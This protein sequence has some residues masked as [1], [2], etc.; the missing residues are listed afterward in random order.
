[1][2][3]KTEGDSHKRIHPASVVLKVLAIFAVVPCLI[4][5]LTFSVPAQKT[6]GQISGSVLDPNGAVV[7]DATVKATQVGTGLERTA[8]TSSEGNYSIP[9]LPI[10]VYRLSV[11][12]SGFKETIAEN[13]TVNVASVTRQDF[14]MAI[15]AVGEVVTIQ[16]SDIQVETETGAVG[17]VINGQQVRELPLNGRSFVQLTQL[18]PGV[19]PQN[20]FDSK[21]KGLFAGVDFSVNG[22]S[23]Q[24]N[25]FLTDGANNNDTGSNRTILL[26]PS[27][28]AIAEF[29][30]LRNS[31]GPEYGQA[32]GAVISIATR[33]GE[34]KFHGSLFYFGRNDALNSTEFF[35]NR[36]GLG[37]DKLRRNDYGFSIGGPIIKDRLFFFGSAEWNK[38]IRGKARRGSVPTLAERSGNFTNRRVLANG[39][40]CDGGSLTSGPGAA[41]QIIPAANLSPAGQTLVKIYPEPNIAWSPASGNCDNWALSAN[42]PINFR[43]YNI[44]IDYN[45]TSKHKIFGRFTDDTWG[46]AFP[47]IAGGLWGDDAFP[48]IETAWT[49]PARQAAVK[50]TSTLSNTAINEVQFSYSANRINVD[51]GNGADLNKAINTAI[52]GFFPDSVKVNGLNRP[53]PVFWG[54]ITPFYS[55]TGSDL[56]TQSPFRNALDIYSLR[57]D[58][59]KVKGNHTLKAGF[60]Y[61]RAS[62]NEDSGPNNEAVQF[63]GGGASSGGSGNGLADFLTQGSFFGFNESDKQAVGH[64]R[65]SNLEF[66]LGDT[67]KVRPNITLELGA[68]YSI[69]FETYD[70]KNAITSFDPSSYDAS[71]PATDPCNGLVVPKGAGNICQGVSSTVPKEF[72]NRALRNNNFKNIAP[73]LGV[74]WDVF[75]NGKTAI[76]GG[77]GQFFLR[78]RTSPVFAALTQ[79]PP[80]VKSIG[81]QRT[82]DGTAF[83]DLP[84]SAGAGSPKFSFD[85][86]AATPYSWQFNVLLDQQLWKDTV[87][88]VGYVGNRARRQLTNYDINAVL[89]QFRTQAAFAADA[90]AVNQFRPFKNYGSIYEFGR[91][92]RADY[93]SLQVYFKTRLTKN[94]I[95]NAAYTFSRSKADFGLSD[96]SGTNSQWA[97][98]DILNPD[99][100]FGLSDINRPHIF[101]ANGIFNLP[102]F[103]GSNPFVQTVLGGW[104]VATILQISSGTSLTPTINATGLSYDLDGPGPGTDTRAFQAGFT[105]TGTGVANQRPL[106][107]DGISCK[108]S[109]DDVTQFVN[110]LAFTLVGAKIGELSPVASRG[111]CIGPPTKN[112]DVSFYKNFA[113]KWLKDSFF[114]ESAKI[115]F[116]LELFNAFNTPQFRGDSIQL[117]FANG[118][119]VCG[120]AACSPTNNTITGVASGVVNSQ[121]GVSSQTKGGREIQYALKFVF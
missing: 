79:N 8:T 12:K 37:K 15:G 75:K 52:P 116:R 117:T 97:L 21:N 57:D 92:G 121:F 114:G 85:P 25:L 91:R 86:R 55:S 68:R 43:E 45:L 110:P 29:K 34:N 14:S 78:E 5:L 80:F 99:V 112:V 1:M 69:L 2:Y 93:D 73:R 18:V 70:A 82:L 38:E 74:A 23:A 63:W 32:A 64:A 30:M 101:V 105:G 100:D 6:S 113:P 89:P 115:Q 49:Q 76:R 108:P 42:S 50:L 44:R 109:G 98:Q 67:W 120:T 7:A 24:S 22:N 107:A 11:T 35:A 61:D 33:G 66:Y 46:N 27:I 41:T 48:T 119:V 94:T 53:H 54:G 95:I 10:G 60:L 9:D 4:L 72:K 59:S 51:P 81:G 83:K 3:T 90:N 77:L 31:Y 103:K 111:A 84:A 39:T 26:Y 40:A 13:V 104:E 71:K 28:E 62:K 96:S 47:I 58:F 102:N 118:Q 106:R 65:W 17:E 20:N 87:I 16:S 56:W 88:E 19:A 36:T